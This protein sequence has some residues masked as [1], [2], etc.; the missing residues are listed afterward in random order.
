MK[1][2]RGLGSYIKFA[3]DSR[4]PLVL[5]IL[6]WLAI[7]YA[8][9]PIDFVPDFAV[10]VGWLDDLMFLYIAYV[11]ARN[12]WAKQNLPQLPTQIRPQQ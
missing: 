10:V 7:G 4:T 2:V 9:S 5:R 1:T 11:T 8:I 6:L 3:T 12:W